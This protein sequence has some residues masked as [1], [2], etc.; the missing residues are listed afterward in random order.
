MVGDP[1]AQVR[2]PGV[3]SVLFQHNGV[4]ALCVPMHVRPASLA[5]FFSGIRSLGNLRGLIVTIPHKP[6]IAGLVDALTPRARLTGVC[7]AVAIREDGTTLGDTFD[8]HGFVLG[9]RAA[10]QDLSGRRALIVGSGG[11]G[12]SIAFAVA[13]AGAHSVIVSDLDPDRSGAL[14]ARLARAGFVADAGTAD[15]RGF[16]LIVNATPMGM[17]PT[18]PL[19]FDP[20][21]L[22]ARA[23][24]VD[25]VISIGLTPVLVAARER[26]CFVQSGSVMTDHMIASMAEFFGFSGGDWSAQTI[27]RLTSD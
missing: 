8:G 19:P 11:V 17:R 2:A 7:N 3:W 21:R 6:V 27:A 1:I 15:P 26:G 20:S 25:V 12:A 10:G 18:D 4:N 24:V 22:D 23:V 5:V 14:A 9:L 13:D 16:D